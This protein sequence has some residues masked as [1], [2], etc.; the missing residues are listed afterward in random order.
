MKTLLTYSF[1]ALGLAGCGLKP[2]PERMAQL[3]SMEDS[4]RFAQLTVVG[5]TVIFQLARDGAGGATRMNGADPI[6]FPEYVTFQ[7][8]TS[9]ALQ[10]DPAHSRMNLS[11]TPKCKNADCSEFSIGLSRGESVADKVTLELKQIKNVTCTMVTL[12]DDAPIKTLL[13]VFENVTMTSVVAGTTK[14]ARNAVYAKTQYY[15]PT[16]N[17]TVSLFVRNFIGTPAELWVDLAEMVSTPQTPTARTETV[18]SFAT[19]NPTWDPKGKT[20]YLGG[21]SAKAKL[22]MDCRY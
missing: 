20:L 14:S 12:S 6:D 19:E 4:I 10:V 3:R 5:K 7:R 11:L 21:E 2:A 1:I 9:G 8:T 22:S 18:S 17:Q 15:S 16:L 13:P